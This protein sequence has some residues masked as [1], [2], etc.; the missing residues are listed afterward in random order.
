MIVL[1]QNL[2][3]AV[4]GNVF[5]D[6]IVRPDL[7]FLLENYLENRDRKLLYVAEVAIELQ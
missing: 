2:V 7:E 3:I 1:D 5:F 6:D 4:D